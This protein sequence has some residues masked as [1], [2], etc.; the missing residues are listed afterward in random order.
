[1]RS[2]AEIYPGI[3]E[4]FPISHLPS[5]LT[6]AQPKVDVVRG[7]DGHYYLQGTTPEEVQQEYA[8]C[9]ELKRQLIEYSERKIL[10]LPG[11]ELAILKA[12]Y[13]NYVAADLCSL[14]QIRWIFDTAINQM[15]WTPMKYD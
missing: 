2:R 7:D 6:G 8:D 12:S 9:L 14:E 11:A 3:P 10:V 1:M 15:K 5:A 13:R 4:D